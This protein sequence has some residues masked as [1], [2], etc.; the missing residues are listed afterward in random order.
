MPL[1]KLTSNSGNTRRDG[2]ATKLPQARV[3]RPATSVLSPSRG[4]VAVAV[5]ESASADVGALPSTPEAHASTMVTQRV[6]SA[7]LPARCGTGQIAT[8]SVKIQDLL[9]ARAVTKAASSG[10][11]DATAIDAPR[12]QRPHGSEG[13]PIELHAPAAGALEPRPPRTSSSVNVRRPAE[14]GCLVAF[15]NALRRYGV[16]VRPSDFQQS[17]PHTQQRQLGVSLAPLLCN[18]VLPHETHTAH[19]FEAVLDRLLQRYPD[20]VIAPLPPAAYCRYPLYCDGAFREPD[21]GG[22]ACAVDAALRCSSGA[23][24]IAAVL[25]LVYLERL[26]HGSVQRAA[27]LRA[28]ATHSPSC[29]ALAKENPTATRGGAFGG[30]SPRT[31]VPGQTYA[32]HSLHA[33]RATGLPTAA[34][35]YDPRFAVSFCL[36]LLSL[37]E[38]ANG[39][40]SFTPSAYLRTP[41]FAQAKFVEAHAAAARGTTPLCART[42]GERQWHIAAAFSFAMVVTAE[43]LAQFM[44]RVLTVDEAAYVRLLAAEKDP[45]ACA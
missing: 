15:D 29:A 17:A 44:G 4:R 19:L 13:S 12:L 40:F 42:M 41:F 1:Q 10:V 27:R 37:A 23:S 34:L 28:E 22:V 39:D 43:Q 7:G 9:P 35:S 2:A 32:H 21:V 20:F 8:I 36:S 33:H 18:V 3:S 6:A 16:G 30:T 11:I 38:L 26:A 24:P 5:V 31:Y 45:V 25:A 14:P